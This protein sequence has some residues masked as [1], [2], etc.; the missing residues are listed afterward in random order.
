MAV[1]NFLDLF[2]L[3]SFYNCNT[4]CL[5]EVSCGQRNLKVGV[6]DWPLNIYTYNG[7]QKEFPKDM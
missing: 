3:F 2:S 1:E 4:M 5:C 6:W 7:C